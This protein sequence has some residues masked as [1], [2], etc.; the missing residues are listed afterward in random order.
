MVIWVL[1]FSAK[2]NPVWFRALTNIFESSY[3][4]TCAWWLPETPAAFC[5]RIPPVTKILLAGT[6]E[7]ALFVLLDVKKK[8][9]L[10]T[11]TLRLTRM[12]NVLQWV[13]NR[14]WLEFHHKKHLC[15]CH[16]LGWVLLATEHPQ[17]RQLTPP[18]SCWSQSHFPTFC[19][20]LFEGF[21]S[22]ECLHMPCTF[23]QRLL[24]MHWLG[25]SWMQEW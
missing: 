12:C 20:L 15:C 4:L 23:L 21:S 5:R 19:F 1:N 3:L 6:L 9:S 8:I 17:R 14:H 7:I 10:E 18:L 11:L 2:Q 13:P 16:C 24:R 22:S 25:K